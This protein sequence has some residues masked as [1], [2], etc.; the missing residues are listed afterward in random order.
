MSRAAPASIAEAVIARHGDDGAV[1]GVTASGAAGL[2]CCR[3]LWGDRPDGQGTGRA[4]V[5]A[6][7][8]GAQAWC[9]D[10]LG[11]RNNASAPELWR[12]TALASEGGLGL[13]RSL[14]MAAA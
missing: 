14:W 12:L 10:G 6:A 13:L 3:R 7:L 9:G 5:E 11:P 2:P 1:C 8:A 4:V